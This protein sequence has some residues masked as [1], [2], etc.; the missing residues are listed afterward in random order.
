MLRA[1]MF[2]SVVYSACANQSYAV[3]TLCVTPLEVLRGR[4]MGEYGYTAGTW[5]LWVRG[6]ICRFGFSGVDHGGA[7]L[8][9]G[10]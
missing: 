6:V 1:R 7:C 2:I 4:H 9:A 5:F 3:P 8:S 10:L